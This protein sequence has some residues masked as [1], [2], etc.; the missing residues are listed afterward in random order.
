LACEKTA[1]TI[2]SAASARRS[3]RRIARSL[4]A[5]AWMSVAASAAVRRS[6]RAQKPRQPALIRL[7]ACLP[8]RSAPRAVR[9]RALAS[10]TM[11]ARR[12][13]R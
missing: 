8:S 7:A 3:A 4:R 6:S 10:R 13:A 11:A 1:F 9:A 5:R 2:V 12:L